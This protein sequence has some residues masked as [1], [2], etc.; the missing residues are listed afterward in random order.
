[1]NEED[2]WLEVYAIRNMR[3]RSIHEQFLLLIHQFQ[4]EWTNL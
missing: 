1:M 2:S 4:L 3:E